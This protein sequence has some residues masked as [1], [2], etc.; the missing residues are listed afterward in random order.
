L[1]PAAKVLFLFV[2]QVV[3]MLP[4]ELLILVLK[5]VF[6]SL[7]AKFLLLLFVPEVVFFLLAEKL[8]IL[9]LVLTCVL[10]LLAETL[11]LLLEV[12][13]RLL[14]AEFLRF[15]FVLKTK[16]FRFF[17]RG[18][19]QII[20]IVGHQRVPSSGQRPPFPGQRDYPNARGE[21]Y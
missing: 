13:H 14:V 16:K 9:E 18:F 15:Q 8:L 1:L 12:V 4:E 7:A 11:R 6:L 5:S 21:A 19:I 17:R 20:V 10:F 2:Q 3:F